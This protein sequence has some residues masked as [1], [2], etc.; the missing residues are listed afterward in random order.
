MSP[1][2]SFTSYLVPAIAVL[3]LTSASCSK[4]DEAP[5]VDTRAG[6]TAPAGASAD[7][8]AWADAPGGASGARPA[9]PTALPPLSAEVTEARPV[10][11][12]PAPT[13][14]K[15]KPRP[16]RPREPVNEF[17][18][19]P[20]IDDKPAPA[21][22]KVSYTA[23][24]GSTAEVKL[25]A[26]LDSATAQVGQAVTA[27]LESDMTDGAGHVVLPRGTKLVGTVTEAV[28]ARKVKKKSSLAVQFTE[29]QRPDGTKVAVSAGQRLEGRG[30]TKKDGAIIGGSAAGGAVLGQ[31]LGGDTQSTAAGAILGG[32]IGTG[33]AL[34]KKGED[35][36][37]DAGTLISLTMERPVTVETT[38]PAR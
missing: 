24:A 27:T 36:Q 7:E 32:A 35:V 1:R 21:P 20:A 23:A 26:T 31:V 30:Y 9:G 37:V 17:E 8:W 28:S 16:T 12:P 15:P 33:V 19:A 6:A 25:D 11:T 3:A 2:T 4:K 34:S 10:T 22:V 29:A 14:S 5:I 38:L 13:A 18:D